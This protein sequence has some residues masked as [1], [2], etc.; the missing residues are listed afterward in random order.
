MVPRS[1]V[2]SPGDNMRWV[3]MRRSTGENGG[4]PLDAY[5]ARQTGETCSWVLRLESE[6]GLLATYITSELIYIKTPE[7]I[8]S[9]QAEGGLGDGFNVKLASAKNSFSGS[10]A[11]ASL[12]VMCCR[13]LSIATTFITRSWPSLLD[14]FYK[15]SIGFCSDRLPFIYYEKFGM[16]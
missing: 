3:G 5:G 7:K 2:M 16:V 14:C 9:L 1:G 4:Y 15:R 11:C 13:S 6:T 8:E 10:S 12:L